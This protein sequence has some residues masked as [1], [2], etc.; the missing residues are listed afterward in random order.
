[1]ALVER[2]LDTLTP[3]TI[4]EKHSSWPDGTSG[5]IE[6]V[7]V[8]GPFVRCKLPNEDGLVFSAKGSLIGLV[9]E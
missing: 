9:D 7:S 1:M 8:D 4:V 2:R 3:G 6:V 5:P